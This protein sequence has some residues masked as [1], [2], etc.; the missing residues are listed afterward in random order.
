MRK[1]YLTTTTAFWAIVAGILDRQPLG[2]TC[3]TARR[4]I[5]IRS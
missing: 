2:T 4:R 5:L 3:P 1:L